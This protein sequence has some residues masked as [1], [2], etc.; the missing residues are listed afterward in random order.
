MKKIKVVLFIGM[1]MAIGLTYLLCSK[2]HSS[3]ENDYQ[4]DGLDPTTTVVIQYEKDVEQ[5]AKKLKNT[6]E[7]IQALYNKNSLIRNAGLKAL[8]DH[9]DPIAVKPIIEL[10]KD[11]KRNWG[12][13]Y[14]EHAS[15]ILVYL[16]Q[17]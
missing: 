9:P 4:L 3:E 14:S 15:K 10:L 1:V 17:Q 11:D 12:L 2:N 5:E 7:R 8:L 16:K 6:N 13:W